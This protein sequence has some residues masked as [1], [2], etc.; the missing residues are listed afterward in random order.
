MG[1][2]WCENA[3]DVRLS[4]AMLGRAKLDH[5]MTKDDLQVGVLHEKCLDDALAM[6]SVHPRKCTHSWNR[7]Q[8]ACTIPS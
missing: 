1:K 6:K 4:P 3:H 5:V 2:I 7:K 8:H